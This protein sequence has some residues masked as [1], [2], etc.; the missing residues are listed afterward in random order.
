MAKKTAV[1]TRHV[2]HSD[3]NRPEGGAP[4]EYLSYDEPKTIGTTYQLNM[5]QV[6]L[7]RPSAPE[8]YLISLF[9]AC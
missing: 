1:S 6:S 9:I 4:S 3:D 5:A 8:I 7:D 2:N